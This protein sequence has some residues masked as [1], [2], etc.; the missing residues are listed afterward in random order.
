MHIGLCCSVLSGH[1]NP[2][3]TLGRELLRQGHRVTLL[4]FPDA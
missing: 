4:A 3:T 2:T 1:V